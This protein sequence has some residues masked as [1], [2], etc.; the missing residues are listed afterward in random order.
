M[1]LFKKVKP[2]WKVSF[3]V[4][5]GLEYNYSKSLLSAATADTTEDTTEITT[6]KIIINKPPPNNKNIPD[7]VKTFFLNELRPSK[8]NLF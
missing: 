6:A 7:I 2:Q 5:M 1:L 3:P 8:S 4:S